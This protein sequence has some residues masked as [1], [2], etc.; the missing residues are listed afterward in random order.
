MWR[1]GAMRKR[2]CGSRGRPRGCLSLWLNCLRGVSR[3]GR[4]VIQFLADAAPRRADIELVLQ[5]QPEL[6]GRA[7]RL[8]EAECRIR[9]DGGFLICNSFDTRPRNTT[10]LCER[11]CGQPEWNQKLLPE[12][13][14][15][16]HR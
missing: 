16:M 2:E 15:R 12:H 13:F 10:G 11:T 5:I 4:D 14:A 6:R 7:E 1:G 8:A 3:H 9:S